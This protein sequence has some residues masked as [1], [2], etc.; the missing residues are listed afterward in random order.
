LKHYSLVVV[1]MFFKKPLLD[2]AIVVVGVLAVLTVLL[3]VG[4][5]TIEGIWFIFPVSSIRITTVATAFLSFALVL[6]LQGKVSPKSLYYA[7]LAV[8]FF[9]ALYEIV[10]YNLAAHFFGYDPLFFQFAALFGW[11]LLGIREVYWLKP[12]KIAIVFYVVF[13]VSMVL[14]VASGFAV[15]NLG[16]PHFSVVGEVF[17]AV[18]KGALGLA[19]AFHIGSKKSP[20]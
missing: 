7:V 11:V 6:F 19:F 10:W 14:W 5:V 4:V 20:R 3:A 9:L 17:N 8:I 15:N 2:V 12:P 13:V 1:L 18:S 16:D